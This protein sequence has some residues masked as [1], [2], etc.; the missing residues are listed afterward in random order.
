MSRVPKFNVDTD[1]GD[2]TYTEEYFVTKYGLEFVEYV[3]EQNV[4]E[5]ALAEQM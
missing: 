4:V 3:R 1:T 2:L 5:D